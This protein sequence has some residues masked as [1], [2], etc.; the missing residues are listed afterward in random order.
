MSEMNVYKRRNGFYI[1]NE[2]NYRIKLSD[3]MFSRYRT[4]DVK[5]IIE[6]HYGK[7]AIFK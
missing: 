3:K 4:T 7:K 2:N 5:V 6:K 1:K